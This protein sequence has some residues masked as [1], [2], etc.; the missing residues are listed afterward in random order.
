MRTVV[1][2]ART[3]TTLDRIAIL[4]AAREPYARLLASYLAAADVKVNGT[5]TLPVSGRVAGR[6]LLGLLALPAAGWRRQDVFAWLGG[7]P[8]LVDGRRAPT[9]TWE[10][11]SRDA[12]V[13][14]GRADWDRRLARFASERRELADEAAAALSGPDDPRAWL[15]EHHRTKAARAEALRS[16]VLGLADRLDAAAGQPARWGERVAWAKALLT[17]LLGGP[18]RRTAWLDAEQRAA[19]RLELAL[20]RLAVLDGVEE[21]VALDVFARSLQV[22]LEAD[23]GRTGRFGE[24]VLVGPGRWG[25]GWTWTWSS[26]SAWPRARSRPSPGTTPSCPTRT[27]MPPPAL[28]LRS[29]HVDRLHHQFTAVLAG[30]R[31]QVLTVPKGDLRRS[32]ERVPSRWVLDVASALAGETWWS[33]DLLGRHAPWLTHLASFDDALRR[34]EPA[35]DQEHRLRQLLAR[36]PGRDELLDAART[37]DPDGPLAP[38]VDVVRSRW[39]TALT[40]FDGNLAGLPIPSPAD[41]GAS[42][43]QLEAWASCPHA[44]FLSYVLGVDPVEQPEDALQINA[45]DR[46]SLIHEALEAFILEAIAQDR[47]PPPGRPWTAEDHERLEEI[48][49]ERCDAAE[50]RGLTGRTLFWQRDRLKILLELDLFLLADDAHRAATGAVPIA[51][52]LPFGRAGRA[53]VA[54]PLPDG[55]TIP[56]R[57]LADRVDR[58]P[59]GTLHVLDYKTGKADRYRGLSGDDPHQGAQHLQLAVYGL[60]ARQD[61]GTPDARI[62]ADYWFTSRRGGYVKRGYD[63]TDEVIASVSAAIGGIV[64]GIEAGLFS[65]SPPEPSTSPR[66]ECPYC[67]PD[68]LGTTELRR[69][70]LA[71][72]QDPA[73]AGYLRLVAPPDPDADADPGAGST[74]GTAGEAS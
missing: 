42:A 66:P 48:A 40:R 53:P 44:Y 65:P 16:F 20:D 9:T 52:E 22:E 43:S 24:G 69:Q 39:S 13:V 62:R 57:G 36:A 32:R 19:D 56:L 4:Y 51:A 55:R 11:I 23:L 26:W 67:D 17:E 68:G 25:S 58:A 8:I 6:T 15:V 54:F 10:G 74:T 3:G 12:G 1:D 49:A 2:A 29:G 34:A 45:L 50:A 64:D 5:A 59:D 72:L 18:S 61:Q 60:A 63:V 31:R 70:W 41:R 73:L 37:T 7:A 47:V 38:G 21:Q 14:G 27:G 33:D 35:T 71:K 28:P 30:A 46:G